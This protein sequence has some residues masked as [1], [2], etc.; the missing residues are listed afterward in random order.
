MSDD[1]VKLN[2]VVVDSLR[3]GFRVRLENNQEVNAKLSGKLRKNKIQV[4]LGD[5][6]E[7]AFSPYDLTHGFIT[8]RNERGR[9]KTEE[10]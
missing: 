8:F 2:G 10:D 6:V 4:L 3:D 5:K 1:H 9:R 7:V